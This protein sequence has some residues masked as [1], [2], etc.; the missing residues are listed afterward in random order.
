VFVV[1]A[2]PSDGKKYEQKDDGFPVDLKLPVKHVLSRELQVLTSL[3]TYIFLYFFAICS[4]FTFFFLC[5][6]FAAIF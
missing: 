5:V 2:T 1:L 6:G 3:S 4:L